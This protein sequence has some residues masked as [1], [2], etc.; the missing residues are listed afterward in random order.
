MERA[1]C[2]R[3]ELLVSGKSRKYLGLEV[4]SS[5]KPG[6]LK[7]N[8]VTF[9]LGILNEPLRSLEIWDLQIRPTISTSDSDERFMSPRIVQARHVW[10]EYL[11]CT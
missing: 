1:V 10:I 11:V 7:T 5:T 2:R 8:P 6:P 4:I 3:R 9:L